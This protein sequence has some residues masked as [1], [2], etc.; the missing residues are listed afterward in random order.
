MPK[1]NDRTDQKQYWY[2]FQE[3]KNEKKLKSHSYNKMLIN[4]LKSIHHFY[5]SVFG[6]FYLC[7]KILGINCFIKMVQIQV[8][9]KYWI[10]LRSFG[11]Y[12]NKE[13]YLIMVI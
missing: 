2:T 3:K 9:L 12:K 6:N 8:V 10:K 13:K 5:R 7:T 1:Q 11:L 4:V